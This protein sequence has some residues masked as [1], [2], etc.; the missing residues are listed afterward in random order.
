VDVI[1]REVNSIRLENVDAALLA[2]DDFAHIGNTVGE[3]GA[4]ELDHEVVTVSLLKA[5][6][7]PVVIA[8]VKTSNGLEIVEARVS[9]ITPESFGIALQETV[10]LD[11][12]TEKETVSY[13]VV[14]AGR[15]ELSNGMVIEAGQ[16]DVAGLYQS[17]HQDDMT[18]VAFEGALSGADTH[19]FATVNTQGAGSFA[20][21]RVDDVTADG[22]KLSIARSE[23]LE[24]PELI[25]SGDFSA[26]S[27]D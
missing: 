21:A 24:T 10:N 13:M 25:K 18:D 3:F 26:G 15:H 16:V 12:V 7:N 17:T 23:L 14:E 9:N 11:G 27:A 1:N 6:E 4:L 19:V 22:F 5:Y 20:T 2:E 8:F